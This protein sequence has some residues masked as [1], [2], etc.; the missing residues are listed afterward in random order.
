M[1]TVHL[2]THAKQVIDALGPAIA[3]LQQEARKVA[4]ERLRDALI[5]EA[6]TGLRTRGGPETDAAWWCKGVYERK[7]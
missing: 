4:T 6:Q 1:P 7:W 5:A 2:L 3:E